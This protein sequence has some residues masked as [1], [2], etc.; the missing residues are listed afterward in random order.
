M[1]I[2]ATT[3]YNYILTTVTKILK[4]YL[5]VSEDMGQPEFSCIASEGVKW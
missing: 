2:K 4:D 3:W 5:R 1:Q